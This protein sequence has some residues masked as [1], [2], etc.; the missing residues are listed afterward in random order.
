M[1]HK[2]LVSAI[3]SLIGLSTLCLNSAQAG[4][5]GEITVNSFSD[6][7]EA[8]LTTL[9][10]AIE[11]ANN[12]PESTISFDKLVFSEPRIIPLVSGELTLTRSVAINGPGVDLLTIDGQ[13]LSRVLTI[14]DATSTAQNITISNITFTGGNGES[15]ISGDNEYSRGGCVFNKESLTLNNAVITG[16][17]AAV[18]GGGVF[19][20]RAQL[21]MID[22]EISNNSTAF[23]GGGIKAERGQLTIINSTVSGNS[24]NRSRFAG[25]GIETSG[26]PLLIIN[27]TISNNRAGEGAVGGISV[28]QNSDLTLINTTVVNNT[29]GGINLRQASVVNMSN[30]IIVD[31]SDGNCDF[32]QINGNSINQFNLDTDG[33][34]DVLATDH[35]TVEDPMLEPLAN[36]GGLTETHRP[37]P[38]SPVID[39][40]NDELCELTDQRGIVRP[41]DGDGNGSEVCDIG[42]VELA[43]FEDV[44]FVNGFEG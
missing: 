43:A 34:C 21:S 44:I 11:Q 38:G 12:N 17:D 2:K 24:A 13:G 35:M 32:T 16:C 6:I 36:Y 28:Y 25:G 37:Q 33:S 3:T 18:D 41:Q 39:A 23:K 27:S 9:R 7:P 15:E 10:E 1:K 42:A 19:S 26:A 8:G 30:S 5:G 40:G 31:N 14:D 29:G 20:K 22:S 4:N